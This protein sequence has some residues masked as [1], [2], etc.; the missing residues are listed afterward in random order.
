MLE[1]RTGLTKKGRGGDSS[2]GGTGKKRTKKRKG[3]GSRIREKK[4]QTTRGNYFA[5][6]KTRREP[7]KEIGG[8][9]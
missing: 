3:K 6:K 1:R 7:I 5:K 2:W 9:R 4:S 8:R